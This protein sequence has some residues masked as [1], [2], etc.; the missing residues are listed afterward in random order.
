MVGGV[1]P[2]GVGDV[3]AGVQI[4][5]SAAFLAS[6]ELMKNLGLVSLVLL[7]AATVVSIALARRLTR[8]IERLSLAT[9]QVGRGQFDAQVDVGAADEI[10]ALAQ[11]FNTMA[12]ELRARD[13]AL[14]ETQEQLIRSEKMAAFGQLGAGIAHEVK[15]PL[16][17]ILGCAQ[18]S[19][20][21]IDK[22]SPTEENLQLIVKETKRCKEIIEN[23]LR[24]SRQDKAIMTMTA[25]GPVVDDAIAIVRHQLE[26]SRVKIEKEMPAELPM[27]MANA[28]Q[29]QQVLINLLMNAQQAMEGNPGNILVRCA[30]GGREQG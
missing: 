22:G 2:A 27:V 24:F 15:N 11:S 5:E 10:G 1:V 18:L 29:L 12:D 26:L 21:T 14:A 19:L 28:N 20:R 30:R 8:P 13:H 9:R 7:F 6:R 3:F 17:G 4:P 16:A 25:L 23:L